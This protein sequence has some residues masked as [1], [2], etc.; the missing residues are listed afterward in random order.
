[1]CDACPDITVYKED[2]IWLCRMEEQ[3]Q[4][5]AWLRTVPKN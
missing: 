5:D 3:K 2:L 4:Y 1:M